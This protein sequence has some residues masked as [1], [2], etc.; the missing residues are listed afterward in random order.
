VILDLISHSE[1]EE[2]MSEAR[3]RADVEGRKELERMERARLRR[4][5]LDEEINE[6]VPPIE[7][8]SIEFRCPFRTLPLHF[9]LYLALRTL[10]CTFPLVTP[11]MAS[12]STRCYR[13]KDGGI[14]K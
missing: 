2:A 12:P 10:P 3:E 6:Q 13:R 8:T 1:W 4:L 11:D 9:E 5:E 14:G 7:E